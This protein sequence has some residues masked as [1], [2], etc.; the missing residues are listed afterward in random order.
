MGAVEAGLLCFCSPCFFPTSSWFLVARPV[1]FIVQLLYRCSEVPGIELW[2][3]YTRWALYHWALSSDS[4]LIVLC[5]AYFSS[6]FSFGDSLYFSGSVAYSFHFQPLILQT[7]IPSL[8]LP[9]LWEFRYIHWVLMVIP[10]HSCSFSLIISSSWFI[11][12]S[13]WKVVL[14]CFVFLQNLIC[15]CPLQYTCNLI[16][17]WFSL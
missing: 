2:V 5:S 13:V 10:Q 11:S 7:V 9:L 6:W 4:S 16:Q 12:V 3:Q 8:S 17:C 14:F 15:W 1:G